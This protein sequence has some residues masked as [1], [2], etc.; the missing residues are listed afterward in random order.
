MKNTTQLRKIFII[1]FDISG[2]TRFMRA[3]KN[4]I[5]EAEK[6]IVELLS[7]IISTAHSPLKLYEICGDS[8]SFFVEANGNPS[9]ARDIWHQA[10]AIFAAF[11][12]KENEL[13]SVHAFAEC[14]KCSDLPRLT[15]KAVLHHCDA[16]FT[17]LFGV[18]KIAGPDIILAH[19]LLKNSVRAKEYIIATENFFF[20][21]AMQTP[22][23]ALLQGEHCEGFGD[24]GVLVWYPHDNIPHTLTPILT[25]SQM[26]YEQ[27]GWH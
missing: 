18:V 11:R 2:Y 5:V 10:E 26:G 1:L 22:M 15:L 13:H 14:G 27:F 9:Q 7:T 20:A 21:G 17:T 23:G 4:E 16:A 25:D 19:R 6:V 24:I 12:E 3:H 8:V